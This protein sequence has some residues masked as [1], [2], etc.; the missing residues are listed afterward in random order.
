MLECGAMFETILIPLDGSGL[1]EAALEPALAL[2]EKF[3]SRLILLRSIESV[4]QR[5]VHT[6]GVFEPPA[7]AAANVELIEKVIDA[8]RDEARAYLEGVRQRLGAPADVEALLMEGEPADAIVTAASERSAGL[9]VMSSHGRG[10]LGRLVF[11]SVADSVL[12][13]SPLPVLLVRSK[14][15]S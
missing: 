7:G 3:G 1:A 2:K 12:R 6:P 11:G 5:L 15:A 8:E 10:G 9:I 13:H 4:S 14:E